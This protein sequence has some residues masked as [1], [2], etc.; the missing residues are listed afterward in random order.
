MWIAAARATGDTRVSSKLVLQPTDVGALWRELNWML[1]AS[2]LF[3]PRLRLAHCNLPRVM[4]QLIDVEERALHLLR[5]IAL[6]HMYWNAASFG[7]HNRR[8][9]LLELVT[10]CHHGVGIIGGSRRGRGE[11]EL[12]N[13]RFQLL[14]RDPVRQDAQLRKLADFA[15]IIIGVRCLI[16]LRWN[17]RTTY[18]SPDRLV[19]HFGDGCRH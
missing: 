10:N 7:I 3:D 16:P 6:Q 2:H 12:T 11:S 19:I 1:C 5:G 8:S 17:K 4:W 9:S 15:L 13:R 18:C 14:A